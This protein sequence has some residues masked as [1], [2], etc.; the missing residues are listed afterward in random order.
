MPVT[1]AFNGTPD[2][3]YSIVDNVAA[4]TFPTLNAGTHIGYDTVYRVPA[5]R[6]GT[7][8]VAG[9]NGT[10]PDF[11]NVQT[12]ILNNPLSATVLFRNPS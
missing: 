11:V 7:N 9:A 5:Q 10:I 2:N 3:G 4:P 8:Q 6:Q 12:S 1:Q